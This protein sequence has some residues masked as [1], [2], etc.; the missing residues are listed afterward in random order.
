MPAPSGD[1]AIV[2]EIIARI[3]G[4]ND[5]IQDLLVFARPPAP[6]PAPIH[7][8]G[9]LDSVAGLLKRDPNFV[10]L[11]IDIDGDVSP[12]HGDATL[13]TIALQNLL[14]NA[15][16]AMNGRGLIRVSL[17]ENDGRHEVEIA[18]R[19]PGIAPE[20]RAQLFRPFRTTKA[21]GTGLGMATAKRLAELHGGHIEVVCPPGGGTTV[22]ISLPSPTAD[23]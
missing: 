1:A 23:Q 6:K 14:I 3:D 11:A 10:D 8:R 21:R 22:T 9:L 17:R 7:L 19:G 13:L 18:D 15:A 12:V 2:K 20:I 4:L 5:L 16:Q